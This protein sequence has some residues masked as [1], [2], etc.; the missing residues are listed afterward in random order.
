MT[1]LAVYFA[2]V[3][4]RTGTGILVLPLFGGQ[5][6]PRL[7]KLGFALVL[8]LFWIGSVGVPAEQALLRQLEAGAAPL[9]ALALARE[10]MLGAMLG[11]AF[12]LFLLPARVA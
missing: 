4:A 2:L 6:M 11:L 8:A 10:A 9:L 5:N 1:G 7:V 3:L 12:S